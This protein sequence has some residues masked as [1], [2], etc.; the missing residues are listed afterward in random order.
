MSKTILPLM[1]SLV[2]AL[3]P[4][5]PARAE[6]ART[7]TVSD[8]AQLQELLASPVSGLTV[9]LAPGDYHLVPSAAVDSTC[10][11]CEDPGVTVPITVGLLVTGE[12]IS[13]QG[14]GDG[15]AVVYTHAGYGIY[16]KDCRSCEIKGLTITG[17]VRDT[18]QNATDA[19]IVIKDSSVDVIGNVI[20]DNIG[21]EAVLQEIIVG[22]MGVCG[23]ENSHTRI[24]GNQIIRNS[25]DGIALYRGADAWIEENLVDGVDKARG[26]EAGGGRG[27][28]IGITWDA[29]AKIEK[30]LVKRYWKGIGVF[31]DADAVLRHNVVE[32]MLTWG[33]AYWDAGKGAP[34]ADIEG[35]VVYDCGACGVSI[36]RE[37]PYAADEPRGRFVGN[38]VV[39][40]GRNPKY[41]APDYYCYQCALA[42]HAVP[43]GFVLDD[44]VFF[45]NRRASDD[46]FDEDL[47]RDEFYVRK[48]LVLDAF[49]APS[50]P[51][52]LVDRSEFFKKYPRQK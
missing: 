28:G 39:G 8:A 45:D 2:F 34:R 23:R 20:T 51:A 38:I 13:L 1:L 46:L 17:G 25:W 22:I 49:F 21:D 32:E 48:R 33:I 16:F 9:I 27:V 19:A 18:V 37:T 47:T 10:G 41:D 7:V 4:Q 35:N 12:N 42:L 26:R 24:C 50:P 30:N 5:A 43:D 15:K 44:N 31:V 29:R 36:T 6:G 40:T 3:N 11:N 14:P 52:W